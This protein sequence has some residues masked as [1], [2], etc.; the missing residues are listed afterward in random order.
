MWLVYSL[1]L[2]APNLY[3]LGPVFAMISIAGRALIISVLFGQINRGMG[4]SLSAYVI[5]PLIMTVLILSATVLS[6]NINHQDFLTAFSYFPYLA[7]LLAGVTGQR[8][9]KNKNRENIF[10]FLIFYVI[11]LTIIQGSTFGA[12]S[13]SAYNNLNLLQQG[14][15]GGI[16][17]THTDPG[18]IA[19]VLLLGYLSSK[20]GEISFRTVLLIFVLILTSLLS[21]SKALVI[22]WI[23][24]ILYF[25]VKALGLGGKYLF[26]SFLSFLFSIAFIGTN[27]YIVGGF[28]ELLSPLDSSANTISK[29]VED[30][31]FLYQILLYSPLKFIFGSGVQSELY[32]SY[33]ESTVARLIYYVGIVGLS[34]HFYLI[35]ASLVRIHCQFRQKF[36]VYISFS[37]VFLSDFT[38]SV[39]FSAMSLFFLGWGVGFAK[40]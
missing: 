13:A 21:S 22:F 4:A 36:P 31:Q 24:M 9:F 15:P 23:P 17:I 25:W 33:M 6:E 38:A 1:L 29:R 8:I 18:L 19:L 40:R 5:I 39:S 27:E 10:V 35:Y 30:Y 3:I 11:I 7:G 26:L 34:L 16:G 2:V 37:M 32:I 20:I 28:L 12:F 14:R